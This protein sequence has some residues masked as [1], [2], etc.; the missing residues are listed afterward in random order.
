MSMAFGQL[1]GGQR[2]AGGYSMA[3][4]A[5]G[6]RSQVRT[7]SAVALQQPMGLPLGDPHQI[8]RRQGRQPAT[9]NKREKPDIPTL[10]SADILALRLQ[11]GFA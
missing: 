5:A 10:L 1:L 9:I 11:N 3:G 6:W 4:H 8:G 2:R 7:A